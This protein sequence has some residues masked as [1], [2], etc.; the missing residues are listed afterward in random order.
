[1]TCPYCLST[2]PGTISWEEHIANCME[3][4]W[5]LGEV[6]RDLEN[7]NS[8]RAWLDNNAEWRGHEQKV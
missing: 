2:R 3:V 4:K 6:I 7:Q 1:M 5:L 8:L